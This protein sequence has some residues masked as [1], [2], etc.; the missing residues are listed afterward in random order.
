[1]IV[2]VFVEF[3]RKHALIGLDHR[4]IAIIVA[5]IAITVITLQLQLLRLQLPRLQ[6]PL[7]QLLQLQL[8]R[9]L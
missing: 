7:L 4:R 6:L 9:P 5:V 3:R 1:M 8:H 2:V